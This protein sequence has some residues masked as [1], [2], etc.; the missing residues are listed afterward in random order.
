M[1][2]GVVLLPAVL[3][4]FCSLATAQE[5][6]RLRPDARQRPAPIDRPAGKGGGEARDP[7]VDDATAVEQQD[8]TTRCRPAGATTP[9]SGPLP[10]PAKTAEADEKGDC[11]LLPS[12]QP[13]GN[14]AADKLAEPK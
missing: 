4:G 13:L 10:A 14:K 8:L 9:G 3:A 12:G 1:A 2:R 7:S 11:I 6:L 5:D